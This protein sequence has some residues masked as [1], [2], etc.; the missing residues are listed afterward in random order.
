M[1]QCRA[2]LA[3]KGVEVFGAQKL[4]HE[5][6]D[7]SDRRGVVNVAL[8][9]TSPG[10]RQESRPNGVVFRYARCRMSGYVTRAAS[11]SVYRP[12]GPERLP[13]SVRPLDDGYI[14]SGCGA[15]GLIDGFY[16]QKSL[17]SWKL[18]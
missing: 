14:M 5:V 18:S 16:R 6:A 4:R 11:C 12:D 2:R 13:Y 10:E 9:Q 7:I 3:P 1:C 15:V 17:K 8:V